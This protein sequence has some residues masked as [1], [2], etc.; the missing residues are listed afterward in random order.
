[1]MSAMVCIAAMMAS[2]T[3]VA[4]DASRIILSTKKLGVVGSV[5]YV[6]AHP[7]DENT[8][9][10]AYLSNEK[11]LR[12]AYLSM[13]RGDGGQNLIGSEQGD[14]LGVIRTQELLAARRIDGA[15]QFFTRARD[16]GYSKTPEETLQ[17]WGHDAIL[18]DVV[19]VIRQFRPDVIITRFPPEHDEG[20]H[21]HHTASARLALEAFRLAADRAYN[22]WHET[23]D[24]WQ[25]K[26][27]V[28]NK[29]QFFVRQ[30][31][32]LSAYLKLDVGVYNPLLG[33]SY[34]EMAAESRSMHKSQGFGVPKQRGPILEYFKVMDGAPMKA[35]LFDDVD[36]TW[37]R[38]PGGDKVGE[39]VARAARSVKPESP[40]S[41]VGALIEVDRALE[42]VKDA[43]W[44]DLKRRDVAELIAASAGIFVEALSPDHPTVI[45]GED[46][47]LTANAINRG[48][49][50]VTLIKVLDGPYGYERENWFKP[51]PLTSR[52]PFSQEL[53]LHYAEP[54]PEG[55][56][57]PYWLNR[58]PREVIGEPLRRIE[59][60]AQ[61]RPAFQIDFV[62]SVAGHEITLRRPVEYKWTDPVHGERYRALEIVPHVS[63][64][65]STPVLTFPDKQAKPLSVV[66]KSGRDKITGTLSLELTQPYAAEPASAPFAIE[67]KG[68]ELE[69]QFKVRSEANVDP[70]TLR[71]VA[72]VDGITFPFSHCVSHIEHPHIP[73]QMM[74]TEAAVKLVPLDI[75]RG[76]TRIGY[77]AGAGDEV[78]ESLR[79]AG[80]EVT[81]LSDEA[82]SKEPLDRFDAIVIG[83][84]AFN[85]NDR[86][87]FH[88]PKLMSYVAGGGTVVAQYNTNNRLSSVS[89]PIGPWPF[90]IT[91][92]RVTNEKAE[93]AFDLPQHPLLTTPNKIAA[94]DFEGWVQERGLYF[95]GKWDPKYETPLS[96]HD[97]GEPARKGSVLYA[98]SGKGVFIYTGLSF[99]R[100]LPAGVPGAFRLFANM[101][102]KR[103]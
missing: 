19:S 64:C 6:A 59:D 39:A 72:K 42:G 4:M 9:L 15:E 82:L 57:G 94:K 34:G 44:R 38:V 86:M 103:R 61:N 98:K 25:A 31:D 41:N 33:V 35:S 54:D 100:Q 81:A 23:L 80:Y 55:F 17:I 11:L 99:F 79:R 84:R 77:V 71:A 66:L 22:P 32:D 68:D 48:S 74:L 13:T 12:T 69:L 73:I 2:A 30:G 97:D 67:H 87:R 45:G 18:A 10:L 85:V 92:D 102:A 76:G 89:S 26:R 88:H 49:G 50:P 46:F 37:K 28:W 58:A 83:V 14:A 8:S 1:M 90:E 65:V 96:M 93:V 27:I 29:S 60:L 101:I 40:E 5:L 7:D 75:K 21:G 24:P 36:L 16:F 91:R 56:G 62:L 63:V 3:G 20:Q 43:G 47:K 70:S 95:A 78:A 51:R 52:D 53:K